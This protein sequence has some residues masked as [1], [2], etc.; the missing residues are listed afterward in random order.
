[1]KQDFADLDQLFVAE[2]EI[3]VGYCHAEVGVDKVVKSVLSIIG[4]DR[5]QASVVMVG[6][7]VIE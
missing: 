6:L 3:L 4:H 1:V 2:L 7:W 5:W